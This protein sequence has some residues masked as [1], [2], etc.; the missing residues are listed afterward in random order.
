MT[1]Q[2][3]RVQ[4]A[5]R[6]VGVAQVPRELVA[7]EHVAVVHLRVRD[8]RRVDQGLRGAVIGMTKMDRRP[9]K[10]QSYKCTTNKEQ[11]LISALETTEMVTSA[12]A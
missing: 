1:P 10:G 6:T 5:A 3:G 11:Y 4:P 8:D 7:A 2:V 9:C 12:C